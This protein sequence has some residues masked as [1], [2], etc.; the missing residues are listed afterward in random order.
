MSSQDLPESRFPRSF[1]VSLLRSTQNEIFEQPEV[2]GSQTGDGVPSL[3][4]CE[5]R[6]ATPGIVPTNNV[7]QT[8]VP[9]GIQPWVEEPEGRVL[10][11]YKCIVQEG[12]HAGESLIWNSE[13]AE[14]RSGAES[15]SGARRT[16]ELALVPPIGRTLPPTTIWKLT[17]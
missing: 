7:V 4:S 1:T 17:P 15:Y 8:F 16:G 10:R 14:S 5:S 13:S 6:C 2:G 11:S 3:D 12:D 9:S